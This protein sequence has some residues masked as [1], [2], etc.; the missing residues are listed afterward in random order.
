M[1]RAGG[2]TWKETEHSEETVDPINIFLPC[3]YL[4]RRG[5]GDEFPTNETRNILGLGKKLL[6]LPPAS[7]AA[8]S[9]VKHLSRRLS[10]QMPH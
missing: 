2:V 8:L 3:K 10:G 6:L 5:G 4:V 9:F 7:A 1:C